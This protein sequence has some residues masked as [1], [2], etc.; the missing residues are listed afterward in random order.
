MSLSVIDLAVSIQA[1][2]P[3]AAALV[4]QGRQRAEAFYSLPT[5]QPP[6]GFLA[7]DYELV[8]SALT[9]LRESDLLP[10]L[11]FL[12][13]GSGFGVILGL[14]AQLGY[15]S[16]GIEL[17][18]YL[19]QESQRWLNNLGL[20]ARIATGTY[21]PE[22]LRGQYGAGGDQG[23]GSALANAGPDGYRKLDLD[24]RS[25][26]LFYVFPQPTDEHVVLDLFDALSKPGAVLLSYRGEDDVLLHRKDH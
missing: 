1:L 15:E 9:L 17:Q 8:Y 7:G 23:L 14:A 5:D 21:V 6:G 26:D 22:S 25:V 19:T 20:D 3:E 10:G 2:P 4:E 12:E 11:R 24:P 18:S 16:Y 13:W